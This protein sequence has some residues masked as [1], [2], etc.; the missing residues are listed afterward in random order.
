M[1]FIFCYTKKILADGFIII[2]IDKWRNYKKHFTV[3]CLRR[4]KI[5]DLS[6]AI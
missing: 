6:Y 1:D 2:I 4:E 3:N 5:E